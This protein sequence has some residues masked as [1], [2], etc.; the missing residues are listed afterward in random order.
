MSSALATVAGYDL[1][2]PIVG[3]I[4]GDGNGCTFTPATA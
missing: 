4:A 2:L 3:A 1:D